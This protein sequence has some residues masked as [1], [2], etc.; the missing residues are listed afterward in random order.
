MN[1][2]LKGKLDSS[3]SRCKQH[4]VN[5]QVGSQFESAPKLSEPDRRKVK[6]KC[7]AFSGKTI[8]LQMNLKCKA[9]YCAVDSGH[10][11]TPGLA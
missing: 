7:V 6:P 8:E 4:Q 1:I 9:L 3:K 10:I 11:V 2:A 5:I